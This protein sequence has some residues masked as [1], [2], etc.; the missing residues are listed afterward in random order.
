[1]WWRVINKDLL[2]GD[3]EQS[4]KSGPTFG[5]DRGTCGYAG[6]QSDTRGPNCF[7]K[8]AKAVPEWELAQGGVMTSIVTA[9]INYWEKLAE[10]HVVFNIDVSQTTLPFF[11]FRVNFC[12]Q[13]LARGKHTKVRGLPAAECE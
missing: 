13:K 7:S 12:P 3:E 10:G 6:V 4:G 2:L 9:R 1:M 8:F 11:E 5:G